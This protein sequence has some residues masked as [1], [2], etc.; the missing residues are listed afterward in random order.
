MS[1]ELEVISWAAAINVEHKRE[2]ENKFVNYVSIFR[3]TDKLTLDA[4][5]LV[6]S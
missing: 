2:E 3:A 6:A 5:A 1:A 4:V